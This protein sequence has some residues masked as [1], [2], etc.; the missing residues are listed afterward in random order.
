MKIPPKSS[1]KRLS[2]VAS[3][4]G[5][6]AVVA[7]PSLDKC[8]AAAAGVSFGQGK[9]LDPA[10]GPADNGEKAPHPLTKGERPYKINLQI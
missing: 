4:I 3:N 9:R 8:L 10:A 2:I 6:D 5:G 1:V 7:N